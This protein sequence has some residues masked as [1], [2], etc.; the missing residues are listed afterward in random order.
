M[1]QLTPRLLTHL[2][3]FLP[4]A[5]GG[6]SG[7]AP[8]ATGTLS[9]PLS[10]QA[11]SGTVY[12][13]HGSVS[14][15]G[16]ATHVSLAADGDALE[17]ALPIGAYTLTVQS[18]W[19]L[20]QV[21]ADGSEQPVAASLVSANPSAFAISDGQVT[22]LRLQLAVEGMNLAPGQGALQLGVDV[23]DGLVDDFEDGNANVAAIGGRHG[24][25]FTTNDGTGRQI[26]AQNT[27][28]LPQP[29]GVGGGLAMRTSGSGFT[30]WG[31]SLVTSLADFQPYD[32]SQYSGVRFMYRSA[33]AMKFG[34]QTA[35]CTE[36]CSYGTTLP[37]T[38]GAWQAAQV[39]WAALSP[40]PGAPAFSAG[41]L[42]I[43]IWGV[44][45]D[46]QP[47]DFWIDDVALTP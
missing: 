37:A 10:A 11:A 20:D 21:A 43:L 14:I 7:A 22:R 13:L 33:T 35:G 29:G 23:D 12:H 19:T 27:P 9:M 45:I 47:F 28:A 36:A 8:S 5:A 46:A 16:G 30:Q 17:T 41:D 26:P 1:T 44:G 42:Y 24:N 6:C 2:V 15:D 38:N 40:S 4:I 32:A 39:N 34:V 31:A 25:W 3:L 18:G